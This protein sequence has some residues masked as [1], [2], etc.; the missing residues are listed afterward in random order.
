M[1]STYLPKK[2]RMLKLNKRKSHKELKIELMKDKK[3]DSWKQKL[4][5]NSDNK[6]SMHASVQDQDNQAEL[7]VTS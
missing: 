3:T 6:D 2:G 7:T 1:V 4:L 5:R